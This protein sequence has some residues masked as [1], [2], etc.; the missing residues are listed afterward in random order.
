MDS[1]H[2]SLFFHEDNIQITVHVHPRSHKAKIEILPETIEVFVKEPPEKSK[3][4]KAVIKL[5]SQFFK[6]S[7]SKL[8]IVR[9][10]TSKIKVIQTHDK[11]VAKRILETIKDIMNND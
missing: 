3:A 5:L 2:P 9:G 1:F 10:T 6:I 4:N 7:S 11:E 8:T